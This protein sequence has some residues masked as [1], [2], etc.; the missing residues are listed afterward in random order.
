MSYLD[1]LLRSKVLNDST[2]FL[3]RDEAIKDYFNWV[4]QMSDSRLN[5]WKWP[6]LRKRNEKDSEGQIWTFYW[7]AIESEGP[8]GA[9][10]VSIGSM[11]KDEVS[12]PLDVSE[13]PVQHTHPLT[14]VVGTLS[15][16][17][18]NL[19][20]Y[21]TIAKCICHNSNMYLSQLQNVILQTTKCICPN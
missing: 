3:L 11:S 4:K 13:N 1:C 19:Q 18:S 2:D 8:V 15:C 21:V 6:I 9:G 7:I 10:S 5:F 14:T 16:I 12:L 20:M 17:F